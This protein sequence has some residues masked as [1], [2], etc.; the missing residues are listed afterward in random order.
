[1]GAF[2]LLFVPQWLWGLATASIASANAEA[3]LANNIPV[4]TYASRVRFHIS[5]E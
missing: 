4:V 5:T 1:M 2:T 3:N